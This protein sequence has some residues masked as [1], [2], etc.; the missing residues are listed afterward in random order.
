MSG[1]A[2]RWAKEQVGP[3]GTA[4]GVF[5]ALASMADPKGE[6]FPSVRLLAKEFGRTPRQIQRIIDGL[7]EKGLVIV[8]ERWRPNGGQTSNLYRLPLPHIARESTPASSRPNGAPSPDTLDARPLTPAPGPTEGNTGRNET[9]DEVSPTQRA[10]KVSFELFWS[11]YP[12]QVERTR[13]MALF[14]RVVRSG[15]ATADHLAEAATRYAAEVRGRELKMIKHP[16][17]WLQ[18]KCWLDYAAMP[19]A[20]EVR[21][22]QHGLADGVSGMPAP[23]RAAIVSRRSEPWFATWMGRGTW[24]QATHSLTPANGYAFDRIRRDFGPELKELG[25]TLVHPVASLERAA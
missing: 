8:E 15:E 1:A 23:L 10:S 18:H 25:V 9:S 4:R 3:C 17:T 13:T 22:R 6:C 16:T 21:L 5:N 2:I 11:A 24:D 14:N 12:H 7:S 19:A 20:P